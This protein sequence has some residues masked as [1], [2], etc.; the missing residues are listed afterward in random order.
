MN[1]LEKRRQLRYEGGIGV[2]VPDVGYI[3]APN[4]IN[5][6]DLEVSE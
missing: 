2:T 1:L 4:L 6:N 5:P 3:S